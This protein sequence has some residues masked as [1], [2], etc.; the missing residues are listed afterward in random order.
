[1]QALILAGG[2]GTRLKPYTAVLPK[3]LVPLGDIPVLE[4]VLRQLKHYGITHITLAVGHLA[5]LIQAFFGDG[6]KWGLHITY[7]REDQP[8]GTAGPI[9]TLKDFL[10]D[11]FLVLNADIISD[12]NYQHFF[13][14]H[15]QQQNLAT[16][17][18]YRRT[19]KI[20]FGV[21]NYDPHTCQIQ[22]FIEKP[23]LEHTVS[24]GI[25][26]FNKKVCEFIPEHQFFGF[27]QLMTT[28][29]QAHQP[30]AAYPFDGYWLD[31]G[32]VDDYE[33]ALNDYQVLHQQLLPSHEPA[34][35]LMTR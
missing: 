9:R 26:A 25:Y 35:P 6:H 21:L 12:I 27:D 10:P 17:A 1:M 20:D 31:I 29:I 5:E 23:T 33:T 8:L 2:Q 18:V 3:A 11:D 28:L 19:S 24:M 32:R 30:V 13:E 7:A 34:V 14:T 15:R 22:E 4:L 16:I